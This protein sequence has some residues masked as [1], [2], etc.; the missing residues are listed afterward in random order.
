MNKLLVFI[1]SVG[2]AFVMISFTASANA[3]GIM[4]AVHAG[5]SRPDTSASRDSGV[6]AGIAFWWIMPSESFPGS[7]LEAL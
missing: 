5:P 3:S 7:G 4:A 2:L 6:G 1:A